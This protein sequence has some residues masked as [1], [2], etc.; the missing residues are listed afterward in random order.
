MV[1]WEVPVRLAVLRSRKESFD[2]QA[3]LVEFFFFQVFDGNQDGD[4]VVTHA[5]S[6]KIRHTRYVRFVVITWQGGINLRVEVY[7]CKE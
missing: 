5:L 7:G 2:T 3:G 6:P 4:T 1:T